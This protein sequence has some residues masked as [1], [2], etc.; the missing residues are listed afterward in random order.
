M[1]KVNKTLFIIRP[2]QSCILIKWYS[3]C[4]TCIPL[5]SGFWQ[6]FQSCMDL[7]EV[8][9]RMELKVMRCTYISEPSTCTIYSL[10]YTPLSFIKHGKFCFL[11]LCFYDLIRLSKFFALKG[12]SDKA[13]AKIPAFISLVNHDSFDCSFRL[14]WLCFEWSTL[15][16]M[17]EFQGIRMF[18]LCF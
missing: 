1:Q 2:W 16:V 6:P 17:S 18:I 9:N 10:W 3:D 11:K 13:T 14:H 4:T 8:R 5:I 7:R 12:N 15:T